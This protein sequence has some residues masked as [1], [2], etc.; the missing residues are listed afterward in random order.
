[1][2]SGHLKKALG[3]SLLLLTVAAA[4]PVDN[5]NTTCPKHLNWSTYPEMKFSLETVN[6]MRV[7]KAEGCGPRKAA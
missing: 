2:I 7:L 5:D 6:G 1:M 3:A 4:E